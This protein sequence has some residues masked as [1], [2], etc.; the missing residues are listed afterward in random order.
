MM[1]HLYI[2]TAVALAA[3]AGLV[4]ALK[5]H[6]QAVNS[7]PSVWRVG[8]EVSPAQ[9]VRTGVDHWFT[10]GP[11]PDDVFARM[12]GKSY[13]AG[14]TVPRSSLRYL[15]LLH[16]D[17]EGR[18]K[19]GEMVCNRRIAA[20]LVAIFKQLYTHKYPIESIR[21]IDDFDASDER[22][23][24]ANNSTSFCY[25]TVKGSKKLSAHA[26]GM[27]VDIN[28]LYNPY[29]KRHSNGRETVQPANAK[30]YCDRRAQFPY[31]IVEGDLL[32]RLFTSHGFQWGGAW[33]SVKDYQHFEK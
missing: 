8:M 18:V 5:C 4:V 12:R 29:Y 16:Y 20:D 26:T 7:R 32:H 24:R 22:S 23:M 30:R 6:A 33:R 25:R 31:K 3:L 9:V 21:L 15:R 27:A 10:S 1:K 2:T 28:A 11:I 17:A 13:P 19:T 14:C